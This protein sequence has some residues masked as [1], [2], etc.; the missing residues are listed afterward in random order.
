[1]SP[2]DFLRKISSRKFWALLAGL[3]VSIGGLYSMSDSDIGKMV[4]VIS[5]I[6][7]VC[8]YMFSEAKVDAA[9]GT[10]TIINETKGTTKTI[11]TNL[12]KDLTKGESAD[13]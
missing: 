1:M 2:Q 9:N 7:A 12:N 8:M 5:G 3:A 6:G 13:G 4:S 11:N 10:S